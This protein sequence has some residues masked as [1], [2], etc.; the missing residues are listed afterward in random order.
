MGRLHGI[1]PIGELMSP[2]GDA[3]IAQLMPRIAPAV[4]KLVYGVKA[5]GKFFNRNA[6]L[7][8]GKRWATKF[9]NSGVSTTELSLAAETWRS[10][11]KDP[12]TKVRF[13]SIGPPRLPMYSLRR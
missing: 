3:K 11:S 5:A 8:F 13:F 12:K 1:V 9:V 2:D 4:R 10:T 7:L 6:D